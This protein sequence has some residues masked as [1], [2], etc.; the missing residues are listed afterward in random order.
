MEKEWKKVRQGIFMIFF[1][2]MLFTGA[3]R[4]PE[5]TDTAPEYCLRSGIVKALEVHIDIPVS[6]LQSCL[7]KQEREQQIVTAVPENEPEPVTIWGEIGV[8]RPVSADI[9]RIPS[10]VPNGEVG[11][12]SYKKTHMG[13]QTITCKSSPQYKLEQK[14][15]TDSESGIRMVDDCYLV[16]VGSYYADQ[17]GEKLLVTMTS[18][19]QVLCMVGEF[20]SDRHTDPSHRYHVGGYEDGVYYPGDGSVL[21]F[22]ADSSI[23]ST[24]KIPEVFDG[25]I[26]CIQKYEEK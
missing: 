12:K 23:Y 19:K 6:E 22:I 13:Y 11:C 21:E 18:G 4:K 7:Q 20:K 2:I 24:E 26:H 14:A 8:R 15:H 5:Q 25:N 10:N 1:G 17:I 9:T 16:A 3:Y